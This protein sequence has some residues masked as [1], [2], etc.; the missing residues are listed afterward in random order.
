MTTVLKPLGH[1]KAQRVV[2]FRQF[3]GHRSRPSRTCASDF[4]I[5]RSL[6]IAT[7]SAAWMLK[8]PSSDLAIRPIR[9]IT[10]PRSSSSSGGCHS[11]FIQNAAKRE[12]AFRDDAVNTSR[13]CRH[14]KET[15]GLSL[16]TFM[17]A[18]PYAKPLCARAAATRKPYTAEVTGTVSSF[19]VRR[20]PGRGVASDMSYRCGS[21]SPR[22]RSSR[23]LQLRTFKSVSEPGA[24]LM[25][26]KQ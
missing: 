26:H 2:E 22:S 8:H 17:C 6:P 10:L 16:S 21:S 18:M 11:T 14:D 4:C 19:P 5:E 9:Q 1:V 23:R 24:G 20:T 7:P 12:H 25:C 3:C 15:P 13:P